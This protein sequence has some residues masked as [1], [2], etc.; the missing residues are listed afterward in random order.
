MQEVRFRTS[1]D[2]KGASLC[3][4]RGSRVPPSV[5]QNNVGQQFIPDRGGITTTTGD[6]SA[7]L[8]V[9]QIRKLPG[10]LTDAARVAF[11]YGGLSIEAVVDVLR[12]PD[13]LNGPAMDR[14]IGDRFD[15]RSA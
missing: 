12:R 2:L 13:H 3:S 6:S 15:H 7:S 4:I 10:Q 14:A 8:L 5:S 1:E 11:G 9:P